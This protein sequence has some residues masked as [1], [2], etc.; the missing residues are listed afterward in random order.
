METGCVFS[1]HFEWK[2][3]LTVHA[4]HLQLCKN[5]TKIGSVD[6]EIIDLQE[7]IKMRKKLT[8]AEHIP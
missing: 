5:F 7:I 8:K 1:F 3:K 4:L 6:R 2:A